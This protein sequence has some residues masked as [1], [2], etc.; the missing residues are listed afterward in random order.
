MSFFTNPSA[1]SHFAMF[2]F[3]GFYCILQQAARGNVVKERLILRTR[4]SNFRR[5]KFTPLSASNPIRNKQRKRRI[6]I[7]CIE[8][9]KSNMRLPNS[10]GWGTL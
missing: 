9:V 8:G 10:Q 3:A 4:I 2:L 1:G 5:I 6:M 7:G